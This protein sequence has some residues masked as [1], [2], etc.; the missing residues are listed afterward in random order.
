[1][2]SSQ[3]S[4]ISQ[5]VVAPGLGAASRSERFLES[6]RDLRRRSS[7]DVST[8]LKEAIS[9]AL[10][11]LCDTNETTH[12][13]LP[14]AREPASL[15]Y[16]REKQS[17]SLDWYINRLFKHADCSRSAFVVAMIYVLRLQ[18]AKN[19]FY[20]PIE[21]N[22]HRLYSSCLVLAIKFLDEPVYDNMHYAMVGGIATLE[23]MNA[24]E[25]ELLRELDFRIFVD[26]DE[27]ETVKRA[28]L[29]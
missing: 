5:D 6:A 22:V 15:F 13:L 14:E 3:K 20:H 9:R 7:L 23:E 21:M 24:L 27:Y 16:S 10:Q 8:A 18:N 12:Q 11:A 19:D 28:L 29:N 1:M 26:V 25:V 17:F 2:L 4:L